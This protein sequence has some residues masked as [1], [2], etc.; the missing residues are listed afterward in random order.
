MIE[1][2]E[3]RN[4]DNSDGIKEVLSRISGTSPDLSTEVSIR[5][6][7]QEPNQK[8]TIDNDEK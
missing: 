4:Q 8:K 5:N 2:L 3:H 6:Q 1:G 7:E